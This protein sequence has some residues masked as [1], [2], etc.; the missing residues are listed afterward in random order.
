[1]KEN[2]PMSKFAGA[3]LLTLILALAIALVTCAIAWV[4]WTSIDSAQKHAVKL[5]NYHVT[6]D[7][8]KVDSHRY[9]TVKDIDTQ[10]FPDQA[11]PLEAMMAGGAKLEGS[12]ITCCKG[13]TQIR[14]NRPGQAEV[15]FSKVLAMIPLEA[16][17]KTSWH[18]SGGICD[19]RSYTASVY[20]GRSI[21]YLGTGKYLQAIDDL[22]AAIQLHPS[23]DVYQYRSLCY[24]KTGKYSLAVADS[25]AAIK[26][27]PGNALNYENRAKAYYLLGQKALG[28]AD[29]KMAR[30]LPKGSSQQ[31]LPDWQ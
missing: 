13:W 17:K 5:N 23:D 25:T 10:M 19:R 30:A 15:S 6:A 8:T 12:E 2:H 26:L 18:A 27:L 21:S 1:M 14:Y 22:T 3:K 31:Q 29:I 28:D 7:N 16:E 20:K 9:D 11:D 4:G 24:L